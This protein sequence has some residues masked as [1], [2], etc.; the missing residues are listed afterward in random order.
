MEFV[1]RLWLEITNL[2]IKII[3]ERVQNEKQKGDMI[4]EKLL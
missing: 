4:N 1:L 3:N 2:T